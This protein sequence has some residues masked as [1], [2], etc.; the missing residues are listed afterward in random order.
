LIKQG[1]K[2][3]TAFIFF[4]YET[5][6]KLEAKVFRNNSCA[7]ETIQIKSKYHYGNNKDLHSSEQATTNK[8]GMTVSWC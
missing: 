2:I 7:L 3:C 8:G 5:G 4:R 1:F 6:T